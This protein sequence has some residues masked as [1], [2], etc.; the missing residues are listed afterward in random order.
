M[1]TLY[2]LVLF[3]FAFSITSC[4]KNDDEQPNPNQELEIGV[5]GDNLLL[6]NTQKIIDEYNIPA[7]A[8]MTMKSGEILEKI[9]L[10]RQNYNQSN[11]VQ[12][13]SKWHMGSITKSMTATLTGILIEKGHLNWDTTI[14]DLT[15]EGYISD[16][17]N[18]S[19]LQLLSQTGGVTTQD[20]PI[21]PAD[22]RPVSELRQEWAIA[23]LNVPQTTVGEFAY[24]NS[25]YV[26]AGVM[27]ELIMDDTWENLITT[28]LFEP[29]GMYDTG[30]GAPGN[31]GNEVHPWGHRKNGNSWT[32]KDP[33]D[34]YSDNTVALGPGGTVHTTLV[35]L[36][37]YTNL[38]LGKTDII[39]NST[40]D[41]LHAEVNDSGYALGW[42]V[43]ENGI[44]HSGSNANWFAQL[45]INLDEEFINFGVTNSYDIDGTVS[46]PSVNSI[47]GVLG[48]RYENSL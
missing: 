30:F 15:T 10:G 16:Y 40:L 35:D 19:I 28:H 41:V 1:K 2:Y 12:E 24:G 31:D 45:F 29:L 43:T 42:N 23:A 27:L 13:N 38:H 9:E 20:Y 32:P 48:Q 39:E 8:A 6:P 44:Y 22:S 4:S 14:G 11:E 17:Q 33:S 36:S 26:I 47:M 46:I 34:V 21:D 25:N 7:I 3:V 5:I 18:I 37:K